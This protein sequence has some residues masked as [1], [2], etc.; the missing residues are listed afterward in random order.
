LV[1]SHAARLEQISVREMVTDSGRLSR[2]LQN[3]QSLY[4]YDAV[5]NVFDHTLEAEC[6][7]CPVIWGAEHELPSV[8]GHPRSYDIAQ[9]DTSI[10]DSNDR[11][12]VVEEA[13]RRLK[14]TVGQMVAIATV[15]TGPFALAD[16]LL[17]ID[18]M[19][20]LED[21]Y[22]EAKRIVKFAGGVALKVCQM[23]CEFEPDIVVIADDSLPRLAPKHFS[24]A[25]SVYGPICNTV[26]FYNAHPVLLLRECNP[27]NLE[28]FLDLG[29]DSTVVGGEMDFSYLK[30]VISERDLVFGCAIP[31]SALVDPQQELADYISKYSTIESS[32]TFLTTE[33]E[34]PA[35]TPPENMHELMRLITRG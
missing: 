12:Q 35:D 27:G 28:Q 8:L 18:I 23:Y 24:L 15:I 3:A 19:D 17:A 7:G 16:R 33:W 25:R 34:V 13:T 2:A 5:I 32:R 21:S 29:A 14:I 11:L 31:C 26:R 9:L 1:F 4:G 30:K 20:G 6:C 22:E 10:L